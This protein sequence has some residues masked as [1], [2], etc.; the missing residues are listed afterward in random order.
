[1]DNQ[2]KDNQET[3]SQETDDR[4]TDKQER[5]D[6]EADGQETK[7]LERTPRLDGR[8]G[9][10]NLVLNQEIAIKTNL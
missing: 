3:D 7:T 6:Q 5:N 2:E 4:E 9:F 1:M 8:G 10:R